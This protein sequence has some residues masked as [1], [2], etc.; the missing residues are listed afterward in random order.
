[1][2]M[3]DDILFLIPVLILVLVSTYIVPVLVSV[4]DGTCI[5]PQWFQVLASTYTTPVSILVMT[6]T[7]HKKKERKKGITGRRLCWIQ[8]L[9]SIYFNVQKVDWPSS[10]LVKK[11]GTYLIRLTFIS[12]TYTYLFFCCPCARTKH[13]HHCPFSPYK[14]ARTTLKYV[15]T[16][17]YHTTVFPMSLHMR[18]LLP[19]I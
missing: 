13:T 8:Y 16:K 17:W 15:K 14:H 4:L 7:L 10:D 9:Q 18:V 5:V 1:M 3:K 12:L 6:S 19:Y 2:E 11:H